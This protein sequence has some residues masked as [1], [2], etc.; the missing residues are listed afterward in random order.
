MSYLLE[1]VSE[2]ILFSKQTIV[3]ILVKRCL[4]TDGLFIQGLHSLI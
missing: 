4:T 3:I 2:V 1:E